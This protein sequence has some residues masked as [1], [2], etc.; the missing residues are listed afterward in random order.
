MTNRKAPTRGAASAQPTQRLMQAGRRLGRHV[1]EAALLEAI[2]GEAAA[3]PGTQRV[4][5]VLSSDD[6]RPAIAGSQ[7]PKGESAEALLQAVTPWLDEARASGAG[8]LRHGPE[9]AAPS[10]QRSCLVA[11]L[12]GP[13]GQ[14]GCLY[15]DIDGA[16]GRFEDGDLVLLEMLA[17]HA[18]A[19][20]ASLRRVAALQAEVDQRTAREHAALTAQQATAEVLQVIGASVADPGPVFDKILECCENLFASHGISL[21]LVDQAGRLDLERIRWTSQARMLIGDEAF[22]AVE[23]GVRS[24][25]PLS[26]EETAAAMAFGRVDLVDFRDVLNDPGVPRSLRRIARALGFTYSNM[27]ARLVWK[28]VAIGTIGITRSIDAAYSATQGFSPHEHA[29]LKTFADQAVIA[30]QNARLFKDTQEALERQNAM[31]EVLEV[32][33]ASPGDISPVFDTIA[34]KAMQLCDADHCGVWNVEGEVAIG[35]GGYNVPEAYLPY[36]MNQ[37]VMVKHLYGPVMGGPPF[38]QVPDLRELKYYRERRPHAV[39]SVEVGGIRTYLC[40][41]MRDG[42]TVIG[43]FAL[44][45]NQVRPFTDKQIALVQAFAAQAQIAMKN[46]RLINETREALEQQ[47][48]TSEVLQVISSSVADTAPV[49]EKILQ[50]CQRL[51]D[52]GQVAIALIGEDGLMHF[53]AE[54]DMAAERGGEQGRTAAALIK[55]QFP[56]PVRDSIHGYAIHK[57]QVLH[58]PD[59]MHGADVPEGLRATTR[60]VGNYSMIVAPLLWEDQGIGG[61]QVVRMPPVPF[62]DK[63]IRLLQ[64]FADQTV[65]AIQNARLF[66]E[67]QEA[68]EQQKASAEILR[69]ISGSVEDTSPVFE[70]IVDACERLFPGQYVGINQVADG[71][72]M[73]LRSLRG[74]PGRDA[75]M[76]SLRERFE[77][78]TSAAASGG[79]LK[80][81]GQVVDFVRGDNHGPASGAEDVLAVADFMKDFKAIAFAP[82]ISGGKGI[83]SIWVARETAV[84]LSDT[85]KALLKAF[86][87]QAV[88][89]IQ[90]A[91]LFNDTREALE[92]QTA[93][94]EVLQVISSSVADAAPVFDK[95]LQSCERLVAC[96]DLSVL[97]VDDASLV[98]IGAVRGELAL[99]AAERFVP[100]PL[101]QTIIG[102]ALQLRRVMHYADAANGADVPEPVRRMASRIGNFAVVVAPMILRDRAAGGF[103]IVRSFAQR[104][105]G[106]F[107]AREIALVE[108]FADQAVIAIQNARLF[109]ETQEARAQAEAARLLAESANE[110]KSA[111]LAT[112]SHEIRTPMNAVIGMSGLLLDT[113]LTEDQRD[114]ASTIRDSGDSLLTIINDILDFSKIEAGR[115]DIEAHPFDLRECVESAMDLIGGR[116]AEKQ[117]DIA[118]QFEGEVPQAILGDVTRLRQILLNLL[119]NSVKFTE[120]GEVV[121]TVR[122]EGDEQTEEGSHLHFTVRDTGIGLSEAGCRGCS[123]S[124]ARPTAA[125]RASTAARG[126]GWRFPSSW[127]S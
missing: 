112:M 31:A 59:V 111:F 40:V 8:R 126:W 97:T 70:A 52:S 106:Q 10:A 20:L 108:A 3:L 26:V 75:A 25:M 82:M 14:Q 49:F 24:V 46:A 63:D 2:V 11:P 124:S 114:F 94:A 120:Q 74:P 95:I 65:I 1:D 15:A 29:L 73:R 87:D 16:R 91:R 69:V 58:Y 50:S 30:I 115:M 22:A 28:G 4:L 92:R 13:H 89:A 79:R 32:I 98:H 9:G 6:A 119:S 103:F 7:L 12:V 61:L 76:Q 67:T 39:A 72:A 47:T 113:P 53:D 64:T 104:K 78:A 84:P 48:A 51:F 60:L 83:G 45:R 110:A 41:P 62:T 121:L 18:A 127:Q 88:I 116:A 38:V 33:N 35:A 105:W 100:T 117:L 56:R 101:D 5:L 80:L 81:R 109:K 37:R 27:V 77:G 57:R 17:S 90:N 23:A 122:A 66:R 43:L 86:A 123:R 54:I 71:G 102:E 21:F 85:H 34:R 99:K 107:T 19:A 36:V 55:A 96:T 68:L 93:T 125:R 42:D 118:Y 44:N